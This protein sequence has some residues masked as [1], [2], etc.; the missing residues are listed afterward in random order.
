MEYCGLVQQIE[1]T[2][3]EYGN[4]EATYPYGVTSLVDKRDIPQKGETVRFQVAV[5]KSSGKQRATRVAPVRLFLHGKVESMK[6]QVGA[7]ETFGFSVNGDFVD[8]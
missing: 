6:G 8:I 7:K 5:V 4:V 3:S 1:K 2:G